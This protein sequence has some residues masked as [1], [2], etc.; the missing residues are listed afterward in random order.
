MTIRIQAANHV[1]LAAVAIFLA[2]TPAVGRADLVVSNGYLV[3]ANG[4]LNVTGSATAQDTATLRIAQPAYLHATP[5][6]IL[7]GTTLEGSGR[8]SGSVE[9]SGTVAPGASPG[10]LTID[11]GLTFDSASTLEIEIGGTTPG[12]GHDQVAVTRTVTL[13]SATLGLRAYDG[14]VP[15]AGDL[16]VIIDNDDTDAVSGTFDGLA[17]GAT[18]SDFLGSGHDGAITYVGGDG[19]DVVIELQDVNE[20]PTA[21]TVTVTRQPGVPVKI[22]LTDLATYW[23]DPDGDTT[24][25]LSVDASSA[26]GVSV[27]V[28][29]THLIYDAGSA[30]PNSADQF[31]YQIE[32]DPPPGMTALTATGTVLIEVNTGGGVTLNIVSSE[33]DG[34]GNSQLTFAGIPNQTYLIQRTTS[35]ESPATWT[36]LTNPDTG[37][38]YFVAGANGRFSFTDLDSG[39][40]PARFYRSWTP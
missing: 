30:D 8:V 37:T 29:A 11:G 25:L 17:E 13:G 18:I 12:T 14:Y 3:V 21:E 9:V 32:D 28:T 22:R 10:T 15:S 1:A 16:Y 2:L 4:H 34:D 5:L 20:A 19:N 27:I 39:D 33:L 6:H 24:A 23:S 31:D 35:L 7:V 40:Y 38:P 36:T 26:N